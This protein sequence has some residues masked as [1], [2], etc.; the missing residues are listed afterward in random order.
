MEDRLEG[1]FK[2]ERIRNKI[3]RRGFLAGLT[4]MGVAAS[5]YGLSRVAGVSGGGEKKPS[6][7]EKIDALYKN[8]DG[9]DIEFQPI[10]WAGSEKEKE[11]RQ[12]RD[13]ISQKRYGLIFE[14]IRDDPEEAREYILSSVSS[15][16]R[17]KLEN[18]DYSIFTKGYLEGLNEAYAKFGIKVPTNPNRISESDKLVFQ[19]SVAE[20]MNM[21]LP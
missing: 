16:G 3:N 7:K 9:S 14:A 1:K 17:A 4:G 21:D 6:L 13:S 19:F 10:V 15:E 5:V 8:P 12:L 18:F 20:L 11:Q 2:E